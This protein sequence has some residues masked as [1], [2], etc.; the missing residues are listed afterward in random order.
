MKTLRWIYAR[1]VFPI[2]LLWNLFN[3]RVLRRRNW[4]DRVD[5]SVIIGALPFA[6]QVESLKSL[7]VVA[8][9]NTCEEYPGPVAAYQKADIEQL[10]IPTID[11]TP[12]CLEDV[13]RAIE[14]MDEA[15]PRGSIYVHCKAG[16]ARSATI[17]V[18]WLI[19]ARGMTP[20]EAQAHLLTCR[21]HVNP[22]IAEREV[23]KHFF[24]RSR[25]D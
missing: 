13:E 7:G 10:R 14:F 22:H 8:V 9:V 1:T 6:S 24:A 16:R 15:A 3:A 11:F 23:V 18:C 19:H 12:P 20:A 2:T 25:T 5:D 17:V 21:Q 4:W